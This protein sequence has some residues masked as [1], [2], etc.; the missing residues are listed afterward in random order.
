MI[1]W[2]SFALVEIADICLNR[3]KVPSVKD[4][5]DPFTCPGYVVIPSVKGHVLFL[6]FRVDE[7]V[8]I[9]QPEPFIAGQIFNGFAAFF[10][11]KITQEDYIPL[12]EMPFHM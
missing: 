10:G 6:L 9:F 2:I 4:I 8:C 3:F 1:R 5:I 7:A 11:I 12:R